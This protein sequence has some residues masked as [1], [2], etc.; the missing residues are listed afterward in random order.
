MTRKSTSDERTGVGS[1]LHLPHLSLSYTNL[2]FYLRNPKHQEAL[3]IPTLRPRS[4][5]GGHHRSQRNL[6]RVQRL[7]PGP[8]RD[9]ASHRHPGSPAAEPSPT[10]FSCW[11]W[12]G[13]TA[14]PMP[15]RHSDPWVCQEPL[16]LHAAFPS[17]SCSTPTRGDRRGTQKGRDIKR[18]PLSLHQAERVAPEGG[19]PAALVRGPPT[20]RKKAA[21]L[22]VRSSACAAWSSG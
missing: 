10:P 4:A 16:T 21:F 6:R 12:R 9:C 2:G 19:T 8:H 17:R 14:R 11:A 1:N 5:N 15:L 13:H 3:G 7:P 22:C 18:E 20:S